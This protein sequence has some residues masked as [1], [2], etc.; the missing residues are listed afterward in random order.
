M[1]RNGALVQLRGAAVRLGGTLLSR[2][3][4]RVPY[5]I[6]GGTL[7]LFVYG[8]NGSS[9]SPNRD[10]LVYG[11]ASQVT[12]H[13]V[14][15]PALGALSLLSVLAV[16]ARSRCAQALLQPLLIAV[17]HPSRATRWPVRPR[18][19]PGEPFASFS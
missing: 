19:A 15:E 17:G 12:I 13:T 10:G 11:A 14:P 8:I 16:A 7:N 5:K 2:R 4:R 18:G 6:T 1:F 9:A 3:L